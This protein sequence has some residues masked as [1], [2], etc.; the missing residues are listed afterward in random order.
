MDVLRAKVRQG[1]PPSAQIRPA[2]G[3]R[4]YSLRT[5]E[6]FVNHT[7]PRWFADYEEAPSSPAG[8]EGA[9]SLCMGSIPGSFGSIKLLPHGQ[10]KFFDK[11]GFSDVGAYTEGLS[12]M[13]TIRL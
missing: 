12:G 2:W 10:P 7:K 1:A 3:A 11:I 13:H 5:A 4:C 6:N 8:G 9:S